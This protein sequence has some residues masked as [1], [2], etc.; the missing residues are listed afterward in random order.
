MSQKSKLDIA[1]AVQGKAKAIVNKETITHTGLLRSDIRIVPKGRGYVVEAGR[2][3]PHAY[4]IEYGR[5]AMIGYRFIPTQAFPLEGYAVPDPEGFIKAA[6][7]IHF[8]ERAT[9]HGR[10]RAKDI[11]ERN[12]ARVI[13]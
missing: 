5:R 13:K 8:M 1:R 4:W 11:A 6:K 7:G 10:K 9:N 3:A 12:I 2:Y